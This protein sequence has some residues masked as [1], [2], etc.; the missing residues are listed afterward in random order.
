MNHPLCNS[1]KNYCFH[2]TW[3]FSCQCVLTDFHLLVI[4]SFWAD[5]CRTM[6]GSSVQENARTKLFPIPPKDQTS[7]LIFCC[8]KYLSYPHKHPATYH[9]WLGRLVCFTSL[10]L[11]YQKM[12]CLFST[13]TAH[14][15]SP[16][17]PLSPSCCYKILDWITYSKEFFFS[18]SA[19]GW[20]NTSRCQ[21]DHI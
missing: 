19:G 12:S 2:I 15:M 10:C 7:A 11:V 3:T 14:S 13:T 6:V 21:Y 9:L 8:L 16:F 20:K 1:L 4:T 5:V 18:N 17:F